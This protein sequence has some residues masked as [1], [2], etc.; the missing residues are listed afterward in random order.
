M[1]SV[2]KPA[3]DLFLPLLRAADGLD[4][5]QPADARAELERRYPADA[6]A[7]DAFRKSLLELLEAG[8]ICERGELPMRFGRVSKSTPE[9]LEFTIDIVQMNGPGP[10][11]KHPLGEVNFCVAID[12]EPTFDGHGP[13]WVVFPPDSIHV[14]TVASGS[15]LIV[16]L[17]PQGA[18]E[19][20]GAK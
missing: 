19:F 3:L 6:P 5:S 12:G 13:G 11:H 20:M 2:D 15:M 10:E 14:P 7:A 9:S 4:L 18:M 8:A 17:L 1:S 16:Y